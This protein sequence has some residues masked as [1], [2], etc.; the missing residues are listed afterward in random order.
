MK[1]AIHVQPR[2]SRNAIVGWHGDALK[3]ALTAPPVEGAA[4]AALIAFLAEAFGLKRSQV[5]LVRGD[6][7]RH[8][9]V[10]LAADEAA[11]NARLPPR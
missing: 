1:L 10:E 7:S 9:L 11:I 6:S 3:V 5:S 8:K 2:A 4:N